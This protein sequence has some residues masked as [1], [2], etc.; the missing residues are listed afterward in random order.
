MEFKYLVA[1]EKIEQLQKELK[2]YKNSLKCPDVTSQ[3]DGCESPTCDTNNKS[4]Q[5][6]NTEMKDCQSQTDKYNPELIPEIQDHKNDTVEV[7]S[8]K[9]KISSISNSASTST[10]QSASTEPSG[11]RRI[12]EQYQ[13]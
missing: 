1:Q 10:E 2:E 3:V 12:L 5:T 9:R 4:C 8:K 13:Y 6:D 11:S 7:Q